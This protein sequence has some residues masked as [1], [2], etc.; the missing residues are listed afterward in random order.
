MTKLIELA[1]KF[2]EDVEVAQLCCLLLTNE[3]IKM[4]NLMPKLRKIIFQNIGKSD[5][6]NFDQISLNL[7]KL[8]EIESTDCSEFLL[9][10]NT[11]PPGVVKKV[12]IYSSFY[13][14]MPSGTLFENQ[15]N[16]KE[17]VADQHFVELINLSQM[18]LTMLKSDYIHGLKDKMIG[19]N[20]LKSLEVQS[21]EEGD[22]EFICREFSSLEYLKTAVDDINPSEFAEV[23]RLGKLKELDISW[24]SEKKQKVDESLSFLSHKNLSVLKVFSYTEISPLS[25]MILS[26]NVPLINLLDICSISTNNLISVIIQSLPSMKILHFETR[27]D[28]SLMPPYIH[29][30]GLLNEKLKHLSIHNK[31]Y[32]E[33]GC[34]D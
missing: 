28:T 20:Q 29:P 15:F 19:Q 24:H 26:S 8:E 34:V 14:N 18:K 5:K 11:L 2:G 1:H 16:I 4:L 25:L 13:R 12:A 31:F 7:H 27:L 6:E 17:I 3:I 32:Q 30:E 22:L 10:L 9:L 23:S 33:H 21:L